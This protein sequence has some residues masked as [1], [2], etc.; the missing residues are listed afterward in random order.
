MDFESRSEP[1]TEWPPDEDLTVLCI[2]KMGFVPNSTVRQTCWV[3]V[4][5]FSDGPEGEML[6]VWPTPGE[7]VIGGKPGDWHTHP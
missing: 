5:H 6:M 3:K 1:L 4:I 2:N 7:W